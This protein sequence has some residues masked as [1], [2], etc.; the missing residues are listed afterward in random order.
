MVNYKIVVIATAVESTQIYYINYSAEGTR[1][2]R[3][4]AAGG[5]QGVG[6]GCHLP[7]ATTTGHFHNRKGM[8]PEEKVQ[9]ASRKDA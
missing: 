1:R 2:H 8:P 7:R 9:I 4:C 3:R 6:C 5:P